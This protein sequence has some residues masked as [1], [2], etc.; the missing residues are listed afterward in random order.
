MPVCVTI[1]AVYMVWPLMS[2][3]DLTGA[4]PQGEIPPGGMLRIDNGAAGA[5]GHR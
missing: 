1:V 4:L 5:V 3:K 2:E